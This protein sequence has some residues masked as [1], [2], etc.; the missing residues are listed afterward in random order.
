[1]HADIPALLGLAAAQSAHAADLATLARRL[2]DARP[3][4][5]AYGPVGARFL[6][7]LAE[8]VAARARDAAGLGRRVA[9]SSAATSGAAVALDAAE[10][11]VTGAIG[12]AGA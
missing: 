10:L 3:P 2:D 8:A 5:D 1:M 4:S 11:R 9:D 12:S 7:A 6:T